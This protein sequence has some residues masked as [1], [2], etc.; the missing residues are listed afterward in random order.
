MFRV[1]HRYLSSAEEEDLFKALQAAATEADAFQN[2]AAAFASWSNQKYYPL[3]TVERHYNNGSVTLKQSCYTTSHI[4]EHNSTSWWI[5]YNYAIANRANFEDTRPN[6]WIPQTV[7]E[8][9]LNDTV[10]SN[11]WI[12]FNKQETGYYRVLYDADN[13][14]LLAKHLK[15]DNFKTIHRIN[16]GQLMDDLHKL[17]MSRHI[18]IDVLLDFLP[19]L[20]RETEFVPWSSAQDLLQLI[21]AFEPNVGNPGILREYLANLTIAFYESLGVNDDPNENHFRKH[22]RHLAMSTACGFGLPHCLNVTHYNLR[23]FLQNGTTLSVNTKA[24]TLNYGIQNATILEIDDLWNRFVSVNPSLKKEREA[25]AQSFGFITNHQ[26]LDKFLERTISSEYAELLLNTDR[27]SI[28]YS[29]LNNS[30]HGVHL[31]VRL[32][33]TNTKEF[34]NLY[35]FKDLNEVITMI[36]KQINTRQSQNQVSLIIIFSQLR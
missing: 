11:E 3:I 17:F 4:C 25:F 31:C 29:A 30:P 5:P 6:G 13:W 15:T 26:V 14:K 2:V 35:Q 19:Y 28:F 36:G 18:R 21:G 12:I 22:S 24:V 1:L 20:K 8:V 10:P 32:I 34:L 9:T 33:Q 16:R 23:N 7:F 27:K